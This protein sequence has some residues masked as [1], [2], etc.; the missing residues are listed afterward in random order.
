MS[1]TVRYMLYWEDRVQRDGCYRGRPAVSIW[2]Q[3]GVRERAEEPLEANAERGKPGLV[4]S[5]S[6]LSPWSRSKLP[7]YEPGAPH[8]ATELSE[9]RDCSC[10]LSAV[11]LV[12]PS[13]RPA[14]LML[15]LLATC[16]GVFGDGRMKQRVVC[17]FSTGKHQ[18][19]SLR[20]AEAEENITLL[21][22]RNMRLTAAYF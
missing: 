14:V 8:R 15:L 13:L 4:C 2:W 12:W 20:I 17:W 18:A 11:W 6:T 21:L 10:I 19:E 3:Q 16:Y 7:C 22:C 1:Y 9:A 5:M